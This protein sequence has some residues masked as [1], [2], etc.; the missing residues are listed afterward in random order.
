MSVTDY[1]GRKYDFLALRNVQPLGDA[2]LGLELFNTVNS[3][4]IAAGV[5]KLAQRW[6]L[7][8]LTEIGSMPA[9]PTRGTNFMTKV[10]SGALRTAADMRLAFNFASF[11]ARTNLAKEEDNTWPDDERLEVAVLDSVSFS[12][13]FASLRVVIISKAGTSRGIILPIST[14]PQNI[15]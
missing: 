4:Q 8:F 11:S 3:G 6:L 9:L 13:G 14:L 5:Q 10:R 12:P 2:A 1:A 15:G 7:E